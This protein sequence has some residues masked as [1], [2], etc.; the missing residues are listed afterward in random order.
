MLS[1]EGDGLIERMESLDVFYDF[2]VSDCVET[3]AFI[4]K[5]CDSIA[6]FL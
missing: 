5:L 4:A 1:H 2:S 3:W 6:Y